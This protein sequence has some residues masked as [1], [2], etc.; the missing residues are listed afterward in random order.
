[1]HDNNYLTVWILLKTGGTETLHSAITCDLGYVAP[2]CHQRL[3]YV[4]GIVLNDCDARPGSAKTR[5]SKVLHCFDNDILQ[6]QVLQKLI[7]SET[8]ATCSPDT[9]R[10]YLVTDL[11]VEG[12]TVSLVTDRNF[13]FNGFSTSSG[14]KTK[15]WLGRGKTLKSSQGQ[16]RMTQ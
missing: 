4:S 2:T 3:T 13:L 15:V 5:F 11:V 9:D 12:K 1:L 14:K 8:A 16:R 10:R 6:D 7:T